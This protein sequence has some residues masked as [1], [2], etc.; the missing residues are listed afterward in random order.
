M[1]AKRR[2][3]GYGEASM[4]SPD[5][6]AA[7]PSADALGKRRM[8]GTTPAATGGMASPMPPPG[9]MMNPG[10]MNASM[11]PGNMGSFTGDPGI[12]AMGGMGGGGG[13]QNMLMQLLQKLMGG[14]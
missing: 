4:P 3:E 9:P 1:P 6:A 8:G 11:N 13:D 5:G 10:S 14:V 7:P 2:L 12:G